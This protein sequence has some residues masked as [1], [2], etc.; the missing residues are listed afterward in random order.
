MAKK[1]HPLIT[2]GCSHTFGSALPDTPR[3]RGEKKIPS[4]YAWPKLLADS[5]QLNCINKGMPGASPKY[6]VHAITK[7]RFP[8]PKPVKV[9][10][11][12]PPSQRWGVIKNIQDTSTKKIK[13]EFMPMLPNCIDMVHPDHFYTGYNVTRKE[14]KNLLTTYYE[15]LYT[16]EDSKFTFCVHISYVD[17]FLKSQGIVPIHL[18]PEHER[19]L[20]DYK[21]LVPS[22]IR[23]KEFNWQKDFRI[24]Y[25]SDNAHPG[26]ESQKLFAKNIK[27]WF[28]G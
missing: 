9:V 24:D 11:L 25:G 17:A 2:F 15:Q 8:H 5:L 27:K 21:H 12:W 18:I 14:Y 10:I 22:S 4:K 7:Y 28:F 3:G 23:A 19:V 20:T 16:D 13:T 26:V 6:V 1:L